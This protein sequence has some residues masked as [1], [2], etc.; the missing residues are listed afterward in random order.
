MGDGS[1]LRKSP[2]MSPSAELIW[3]GEYRGDSSFWEY[4]GEYS[5]RVYLGDP[6]STSPRSRDWSLDDVVLE[7]LKF[8]LKVWDLP[9]SYLGESSSVRTDSSLLKGVAGASSISES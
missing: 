5:P 9:G 8:S 6:S 1:Y 7:I 3:A 4:V 2:S